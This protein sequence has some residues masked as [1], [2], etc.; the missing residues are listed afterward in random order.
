M[1]LTHCCLSICNMKLFQIEQEHQGY[2]RAVWKRLK[3]G[4]LKVPS[5]E[6]LYFIDRIFTL[7]LV[8][9]THF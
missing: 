9:R 4:Y 1:V 7:I 8:C 5:Q 3:A 2:Q 6:F